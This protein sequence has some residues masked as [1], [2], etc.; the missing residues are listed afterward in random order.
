MFFLR[1]RGRHERVSTQDESEAADN[2]NSSSD[3]NNNISQRHHPPIRESHLQTALAAAGIETNR[4]SSI[5]AAASSSPSSENNSAA[6][7]AAIDLPNNDHANT[8][9]SLSSSSTTPASVSPSS[10][11]ETEQYYHSATSNNTTSAAEHFHQHPAIR[12][13]SP[14]C[15]L[16]LLFFLLRLWIEAIIEKDIGLIFISLM[17]TTWYYRWYLIRRE[18]E[19]DWLE[20]ANENE[21]IVEGGGG[22]TTATTATN[23]RRRTGTGADAA[24]D[25]DPD[26]GLMSF[27]AQLA[28]AI[29][30]SQR[31]MLENGGYGGNDHSTSMNGP[32]VTNEAKQSWDKYEWGKCQQTTNKLR[33]VIHKSDS[34]T[35]IGGEYNHEGGDYGSVSVVENTRDD[36]PEGA[37]SASPS[38]SHQSTKANHNDDASSSSHL[39]KL[40]GGL[41]E[42]SFDNDEE[43]SCSICLCEYENGETVTKLPCNH[44]YHESC[45]S[46]WTENHVRCPL[47][48]YDLMTGFEQPESV[49]NQQQNNN[50]AEQLAFRN[51]A[52][53][54]LGGRRIRTRASRRGGGGGRRA[55]R[56]ASALAAAEESIV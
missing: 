15:T 10:S 27:Q 50:E 22:D 55:S 48:N 23:T 29:L 40:E 14:T 38:S 56:Y 41:L 25:F 26:L 53:S 1:P 5:A 35:K 16:L 13:T 46:S 42:N 12:A 18:A 31:Q 17:G 4:Q 44:I 51:M 9:D 32:G 45:L 47:C 39:S 11:G 20:S 52:L 21:F 30:E 6:A 28:L 8:N 34:K 19:R 36:H 43:P 3:N 33:D 49:R 54:A 24:V 2:N 7:P 37:Q